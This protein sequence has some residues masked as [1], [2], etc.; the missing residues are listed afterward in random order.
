[1]SARPRYRFEQFFATRRIVAMQP[2]PDGESVLFVSDISGQF[3]LWRVASQG[4]WPR[5]LTLFTEDSVRE[6]IFNKDGSR[7]AFLADHHG[8]E[9]FQVYLMDAVGGWPER[10]TDR[11]D[12]QYSLTG[13][14][15]AAGTWPS[16]ATRPTRRT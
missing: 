16:R 15:P 2:A 5:Q 10:I 9:Q 14:S 4:G 1:M 3:N 8:D 7:I 12:V 11:P 6:A 13:F